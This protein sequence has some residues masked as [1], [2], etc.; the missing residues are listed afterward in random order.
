MGFRLKV[1]EDGELKINL[2][3]LYLLIKSGANL[4]GPY[5]YVEGDP[6]TINYVLNGLSRY[7]DFEVPSIDFCPSDEPIRVYDVDEVLKDFC[8]E[9]YRYFNDRCSACAIKVYSIISESW[10]F[11]KEALI[12]LFEAIINHH[13]PTQFNSGCLVVAACPSSY[14]DASKLMP[15]AYLDGIELLRRFINDLLGNAGSMT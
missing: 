7:K 11:S 14:E 10:L 5:L 4:D 6:T 8:I 3:L 2:T 9:V 1:L 13:L 15:G 12:K